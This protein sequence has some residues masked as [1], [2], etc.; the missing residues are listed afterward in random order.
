LD[1]ASGT[2]TLVDK[3]TQADIDTYRW[4]PDG[5]WLAYETNHPET[6]L[7]SIAVYSL[8]SKQS[9]LLGDGLTFDFQP[10]WSVDGKHLFFLSNRD[11]SLNFSDFEFNYVYDNATRVYAAALTSEVPPLFPLASD[12]VEIDAGNDDGEPAIE[13]K[14][15]KKES[16][17]SKTEETGEKEETVE[18]SVEVEG[19]AERTVALPGVAAGNY[20][21][22]TATE[23]A[24]LYRKLPDGGEP[25][26]VRYDLEGRE[27][28]EL[29][30]G[31]RAYVLAA[32]GGK[33]LYRRGSDWTIASASPGEEGEALDLSGLKMKLDPKAE[34][35]QMFAEVW[36]IGRDWFYDD[37]MHGIDWQAMRERYEALL[38]WVA[39]RSDL[40]FL[41]GEMVSELEAGHAYVQRGDEPEVERVEGGMLGAELAADASGFYRIAKI[42]PGENWDDDYRSPLAEPG[43]EVDEGSFLIAIDGEE[44]TT[45]DNPFR[46]LEGKGGQQ[47]ALTVNSEPDRNGARTVTVRTITSERNLRYLDWVL[48][49]AALVEELSG[50]RIGYIHLP[51]TAQAGNRMLQKMFY[52]QV[53]KDALIVDDRYNGG[54]FIPD[55]MIEML[56]RT[57]LSFWARRGIEAFSTPG[58]AHDGP[59]VMLINGY[60]ASGGDALPYYFR[61][62]GLGPIIGTTTWGGLIGISGNPMLVDGG[63][64]LYPTFRF[65][66]T[67]GEWAVEGEGVAP[68][69]EVWDL[70]EAI[71]AGRD[72]SIEKGV[73]VLLEELAD[74]TGRRESPTPP[75]MS[76]D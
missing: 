50:G 20:A 35:R 72:P 34:W 9:S 24:V 76:G 64:V 22:L 30:S 70:P 18:V 48:S 60:A 16:A 51:N 46:L 39:H 27:E 33:L 19:F 29:A 7:P 41:F 23:G 5:K 11:Y 49:R 59:K 73:E 71:A 57:T 28:K 55:R 15:G 52:S 45:R 6:R 2:Q 12:E 42:Y 68:D 66:T 44:L 38:P 25:A 21:D 17:K 4:S 37:N 74:Y 10:A 62:R 69:I 56:S 53:S 3:G 36:R 14:K 31:V 8:T 47:V 63:G 26:L 1:V 32:R 13:T 40:D 61:K 43:I 54:G 75:N 65:Y 58:F 67:D